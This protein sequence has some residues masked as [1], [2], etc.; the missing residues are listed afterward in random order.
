[1]NSILS[2]DE[3]TGTTR[4]QEDE[5]IDYFQT[6]NP[7]GV[8]FEVIPDENTEENPLARDFPAFGSRSIKRV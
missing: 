6:L 4:L 1:M 2:A 8:E 3:P 5:A 7:D